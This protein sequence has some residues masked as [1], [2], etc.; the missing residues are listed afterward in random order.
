MSSFYIN[1][2]MDEDLFFTQRTSGKQIGKTS[3][4]SKPAAIENLLHS[5]D[6]YNGSYI[7]FYI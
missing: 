5:Q 7:C 2:D 3:E 1:D 4:A 6:F